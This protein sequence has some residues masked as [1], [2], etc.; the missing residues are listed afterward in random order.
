VLFENEEELEC[1]WS[2]ESSKLMVNVCGKIL[3]ETRVV[4]TLYIS[5]NHTWMAS[6]VSESFQIEH[7]L[8]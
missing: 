3:R 5:A 7:L 1:R 4:K 2:V 8:T 6:Y